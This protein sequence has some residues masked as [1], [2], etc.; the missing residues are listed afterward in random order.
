MIKRHSY[1]QNEF[2]D[3]AVIWKYYKLPRFLDLIEKRKLFFTRVDKF[4]DPN[5]FPI[6]AKDAQAFCM[7]ID[8]Y[9]CEFERIK[10]Q[11]YV[12]CWRID[13]NES[14]GMWSAY[15]DLETGIAIKT[16]AGK[17]ID[18]YN[19]NEREVDI[20]IGK[21]RYIDETDEMVQF[22]GMRLNCLYIVFA[23]TKPYEYENELRLAFEDSENKDKEYL[24]IDIN[25]CTL[26]EEI[27]VGAMAHPL[28][29]QMVECILKENGINVPVTKSNI[30]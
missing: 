12:N 20:T 28:Y 25:L 29:V 19:Y 14:F 3:G 27:R 4:S 1:V 13:D 24:S 5:E 17:L 8:D 23:K 10:R 11:S 7:S 9:R 6:I 18:A 30:K 22:P 15:S 2:D 21:V 16:T 26:I